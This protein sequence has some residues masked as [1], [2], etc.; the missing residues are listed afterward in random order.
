MPQWW[1]TS[2]VK[3]HTAPTSTTPAATHLVTAAASLA[4]TTRA[5]DRAA[6]RNS[7][8]VP[9]SHSSLMARMPNRVPENRTPKAT[10]ARANAADQSMSAGWVVDSTTVM[11]RPSSCP[12]AH[13]W[14]APVS[15]LR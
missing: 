11:A 12:S 15:R 13:T 9:A 2:P 14:M 4:A 10:V 5:V 3:A 6:I 8:I 1:G 7:T